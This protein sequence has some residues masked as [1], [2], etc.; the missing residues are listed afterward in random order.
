MKK[1]TL[2]WSGAAYECPLFFFSI[3]FL[4]LLI[5]PALASAEDK[6]ERFQYDSEDNIVLD[7]VTGKVYGFRVQGSVLK[8][9]VIDYIDG[10]VRASGNVAPQDR[11]LVMTDWK[12]A[13]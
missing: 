6:V 13:Q 5:A 1:R 7:T 3:L 4:V 10:T 2:N 11:E 9:V 8:H 12:S